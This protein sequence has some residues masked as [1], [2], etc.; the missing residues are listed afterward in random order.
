MR[1][2]PLPLSL[3]VHPLSPLCTD[4]L[5]I[6]FRIP[7]HLSLFLRSNAAQVSPSLRRVYQLPGFEDFERLSVHLNG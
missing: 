6:V 3:P 2:L 7:E 4:A 1:H 5:Q